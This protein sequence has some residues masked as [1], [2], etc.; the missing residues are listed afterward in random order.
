MKEVER[1]TPDINNGL[2]SEQVNNRLLDGLNNYDSG[3]KSKSIKEIIASNCFTFFNMLNITLGA[4]VFCAGLFS[5][6]I[7]EGIKNSLFI[8]IIFVNS[9]ISIVEEI[10]SKKIIDRLSLLSESKVTVIRDGK[11]QEK[12]VDEI[13]LDDIVKL[14]SGHQV[15]CD[16]FKLDM[17]SH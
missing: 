13:V 15:V 10:I 7:Y 17:V 9:F 3:P 4:S 8:G 5:N 14:R 11:E 6:Q 1:F 16:A 2:T 12:N